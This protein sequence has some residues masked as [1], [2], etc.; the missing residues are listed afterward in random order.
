AGADLDRCDEDAVAADVR[1]G[2]DRRAVLVG[3][4]VVRG[5]AAGAEV[6]ALADI[7]V[8]E[9]GEV[10][11]LRGGA[12]RRVLDLDEVADVDVGAELG[13]AAQPRE[14]TDP[15]VLADARA[16]RFAVDQ[17]VGQDRRA[18]GDAGV[19][20]RAVGA[21][22]DLVAELDDAFENAADVDLDVA[23]AT[24][25]AAGV[26]TRRV[27]DADALGH[28]TRGGRALVA[29]LEVGE[30]RR[31]VD[32]EHLGFARR[33]DA[34][35][36]DAFADGDADDVGEVVLAGG[37]VVGERRQ[38]ALQVPRRRRHR[39]GVDLAKR[40]HVGAGVL[41]FDDRG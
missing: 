37:V 36:T 17:R 19:L 8:A 41:L 35:D 32:A 15:G 21:D 7:G 3:A 12:E 29:A 28:E 14:R 13:A 23:A 16:E 11:R 26:E 5:D 40:T 6:D 38:P 4:V 2:A 1:I 18:G 31:A 27:G 33:R 24:Q 9:I 20:Q 25:L 30:L 10:V 39:A 22:A 34:D